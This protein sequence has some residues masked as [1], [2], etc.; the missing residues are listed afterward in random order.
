[1]PPA[2][3]LP[4]EPLPYHLDVVRYL[5]AQEAELWAWFSAEKLRAEQSESVRLDLLKSTYRIEREAHPALHAAAGEVAAKLGLDAPLTLYQAQGGNGLNASLAY[6]PGEAH[7]VLHGPVADRLGPLELRSVLGHEVTHFLLLDRWKEYLVASQILAAMTNDEAAEAAHAATARRFGLYTEV[8]CDRGAY[9]AGGDLA[10]AVAAL[11]KIET[12]IAEAS[13]DSFLRQADEIFEKGQPHTGGV[14]HPEAFVR[15]RAMKLWAEAPQRAAAELGR[16]IE[17]P[18]SLAD[19]D[20]LGQVSVS[21]LTRRLVAAFLR[22]DWLRTEPLLAHARLFFDD[23][24]PPAAADP[25]LGADLQG[26]DANL[27][28][29]WCY[30]LLDFAAA[31]RD[32]EDAP[33]AAALLLAD[34][35]GLGDRFRP[36]A[37]KNLGL[38]KKQLDALDAG[39]AAVVAKASE[40]D[41]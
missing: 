3:P 16:V 8:Y 23:F 37:A 24:A 18:L 33:L 11:V 10:A 26:G 20:L 12:G 2:P 14:T 36:I 27:L 35:L 9:L 28:D 19:L 5:Q 15:A 30:V 31:D 40:A 38:R 32:L 6:V 17:G 1:M 7:L 22:A 41:A 4:L 25:A 21:A 34:E 13:A 39:A 29:Y